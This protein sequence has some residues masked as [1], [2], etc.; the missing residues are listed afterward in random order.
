MVAKR[1]S[2]APNAPSRKAAAGKRV[3]SAP[4][5]TSPGSRAGKAKE[6]NN[7]PTKRTKLAGGRVEIR[8]VPKD[9]VPDVRPARDAHAAGIHGYALAFAILGLAQ[10]LAWLAVATVKKEPGVYRAENES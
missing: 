6:V 10:L 5:G 9:R 7:R 2:N 3:R 1:A 8:V 4:N